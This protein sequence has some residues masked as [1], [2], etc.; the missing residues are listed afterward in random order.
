MCVC[1]CVYACVWSESDKWSVL[2]KGKSLW[3]HA[4]T[5]Q[6]LRR[7]KG[8]R[9]LSC[10]W[11]QT[12]VWVF[13]YTCVCVCVHV[14]LRLSTFSCT[15]DSLCLF[16][17]RWQQ[18]GRQVNEQ[19]APGTQAHGDYATPQSIPLSHSHTYTHISPKLTTIICF[20]ALCFFAIIS[21]L[22]ITG[23]MF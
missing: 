8:R 1:V 6:E 20:F 21:S 5:A 17:L 23:W 9:K 16:S 22:Y 3:W 18:E 4:C 11:L 7:E 14:C 12:Q 15:A 13:T 10:A 2:L 19:P